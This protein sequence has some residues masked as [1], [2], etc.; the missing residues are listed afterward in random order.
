MNRPVQ[1]GALALILAILA[2]TAA[3]SQVLA[4]PT[5]TPTVTAEKESWYLTGEPITYA[6]NFYYPA[7][8][9]VFFNPAEMVRSGF[10]GGIPLYARTTIEPYSVIYV[11]LAGGRMQPY[12]RPRDG[13]LTGTTGSLPSTLPEPQATVPPAGLAPQAAGPPAQTT[14]VVPFQ[15]RGEPPVTGDAGEAAERPVGTAGTA[16]AREPRHTRIGGT[17]RGSQAIFI[18][19]DGTRWYPQG[20][21]RTIDR[22]D[23]TRA[24]EHHGFTV[25]TPA[26]GADLIFVP[27]TPGSTLAV[28]YARTPR[29]I[30]R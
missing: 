24:G 12:A 10:F 17:P 7:G 3:F 5:A 9:E 16:P 26:D 21:A 18:E 23:L 8:P 25:W 4:V 28:P 2:V 1:T 15:A 20:P 22:S 29:S 6:G 30:E 13:E 19:F 11:P 14:I 27:V